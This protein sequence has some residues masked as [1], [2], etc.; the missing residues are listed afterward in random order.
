MYYYANYGVENQLTPT[1]V[2]IKVPENSIDPNAPWNDDKMERESYTK[3]L[4]ELIKGV[5][6]PLIIAIDGDWGTGKTYLLER[7]QADLRKSSKK[8]FLLFSMEYS[9]KK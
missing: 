2:A 5:S 1:N 3:S 4:T 9:T 7:W 8:R 6:E